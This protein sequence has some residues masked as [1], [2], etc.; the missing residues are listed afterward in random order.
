[1]KRLISLL[2]LAVP[3]VRAWNAERCASFALHKS[4]IAPVSSFSAQFFNAGDLVNITNEFSSINTTTLP[5]FCREFFR[6]CVLEK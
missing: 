4:G 5:A 6:V 1:M 3:L 2:V